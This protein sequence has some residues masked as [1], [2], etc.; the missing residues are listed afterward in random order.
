LQPEPVEGVPEARIGGSAG[1]GDIA[2]HPD[3]ENNG[4]VYLTYNKP[5]GERGSLGVARGVWSGDRLS[6]VEDVFASEDAGGIARL[7]F[8]P[9]GK[10]YVST[11]VGGD[12]QNAQNPGSLGGKVLRLNDDG[13]VPEDNPFVGVAGHRPEIFTLG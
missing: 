12:P 4:Y 8:G 11:F 2:V 13:S 6:D 5:V 9:D 7:I 10:L 3:F 1:L